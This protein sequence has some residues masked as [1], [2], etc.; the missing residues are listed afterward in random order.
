MRAYLTLLLSILEKTHVCIYVQMYMCNRVVSHIYMCWYEYISI[1]VD[2]CQECLHCWTFLLVFFAR[3]LNLEKIFYFFWC[4][5]IF[6]F[7]Y[8]LPLI[9]FI[10][11]YLK[12]LYQVLSTVEIFRFIICFLRIWNVKKLFIDFNLGIYTYQNKVEI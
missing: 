12:C 10:S 1:C 4:I 6:K 3:F 2:Y 11:G 5:F 9:I 8:T 7:L